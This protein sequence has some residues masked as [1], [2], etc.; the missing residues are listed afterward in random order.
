MNKDFSD[1][2]TLSTCAFAIKAGEEHT[3]PYHFENALNGGFEGFE[4]SF[5]NGGRAEDLLNAAKT[6][7]VDVC[8]V[9]GLMT[10]NSCAKDKT[11]RDKAVEQAYTFLSVFAEYAP[12][13]IV[14]HYW[15]RYNDPDMAKYF[16]DSV[17]RLLEKTDQYGFTFC[18][19]NAPYKPEVNERYP[20]IAEVADFIRSFGNDRMFMTFDVNHANLNEDV[21]YAVKRSS[22]L[23]RHI[24][25][26]DNHGHR[27][28]H[29]LPGEGIIDLKSV[30]N[31]IFNTD[32]NGPCNFEFGFPKGYTADCNDYKKVYE[33]IKKNIF[34][35]R[36]QSMI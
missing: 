22:G 35:P 18:M 4:L 32:Y 15:S 14:E 17:A 29:L 36:K 13:S 10:P 33:Y 8:A 11:L 28:E 24:H 3:M 6:A 7:Q 26:S 34:T 27:E 9:H 30:V 2:I 16:Q 31:A 5:I 1:K 20:D 19:E 25:V 23:I 12:C 21:L